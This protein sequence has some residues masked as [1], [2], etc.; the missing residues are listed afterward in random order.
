MIINVSESE[1]CHLLKH[2]LCYWKCFTNIFQKIACLQFVCTFGINF[3][4]SCPYK[5]DIV[6]D[7]L[8]RC[9]GFTFQRHHH[10]RFPQLIIV[11]LLLIS[12]VPSSWCATHPKRITISVSSMKI[13]SFLT[14]F[15]FVNK[16]RTG[17]CL[18]RYYYIYIVLSFFPEMFQQ[19]WLREYTKSVSLLFFASLINSF[20]RNICSLLQFLPSGKQHLKVLSCRKSSRCFNVDIFWTHL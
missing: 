2:L 12:R 11:S 18:P 1:C 10:Q 8:W 15:L 17:L 16:W 6:R 5:P 19:F 14:S 3:F 9:N 4:F 13:V 7:L 20:F